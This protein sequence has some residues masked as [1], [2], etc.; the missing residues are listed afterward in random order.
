MRAPA[1]RPRSSVRPRIF[2]AAGQTAM[3]VGRDVD[4]GV[5]ETTSPLMTL[6]VA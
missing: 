2:G 1:S 6:S 3:K 5:V 4:A